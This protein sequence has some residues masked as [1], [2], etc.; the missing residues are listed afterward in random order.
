M[1]FDDQLLLIFI[2]ARRKLIH[3]GRSF[4]PTILGWQRSTSPTQEMTP[5]DI[6]MESF[7]ANR[8]IG[9]RYLTFEETL[10]FFK[11]VTL[12]SRI[13]DDILNDLSY[14]MVNPIECMICVDLDDIM[15]VLNVDGNFIFYR[16]IVELEKCR[17]IT[18]II[19]YRFIESQKEFIKWGTEVERQAETNADKIFIVHASKEK[20][21]REWYIVATNCDET[22]R[23]RSE[24][25]SDS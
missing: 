23:D 8:N 15:R 3:L 6:R 4:L 11:E 2:R 19:A 17:A 5:P 1:K 20:T 25:G 24:S 18:G 10:D 21:E 16:S 22:L 13:P 9:D 7:C 14:I 12:S